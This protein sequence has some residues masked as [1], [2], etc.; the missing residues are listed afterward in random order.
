MNEYSGEIQLPRFVVRYLELKHLGVRWGLV[1]VALGV[2][3]VAFFNSLETNA[4]AIAALLIL[5]VAATG[6]LFGLRWAV[7][8]GIVF[9]FGNMV[10][11]IALGIYDWSDFVRVSIGPGFFALLFIGVLVGGFR[12][13]LGQ[14][15]RQ[16]VAL[17]HERQRLEAEIKERRAIEAELAR[18]NEALVEFAYVVSHDLKAPLRGI[19]KLATWIEEDM[20]DSLS[21]ESQSYFELL[22]SR[23][24][25]MENL[26]TGILTYSRAGQGESQIEDVDVGELLNEIVVTLA[27][28]EGFVVEIGADM[29]VLHTDRIK[30]DQIF[31]NFLSNALKYHDKEEG[32]I[33]V[34]VA[35]TG[36]Y[37]RFGVKDDG[38]GIP[39][40]QQEKVFGIFHVLQSRDT[41]ESTGI[42]L[43]VVKKLVEETGGE[44]G[45]ISEGRGTEF[46]FSWP[47]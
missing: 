24:K 1:G 6:L 19:V 47:K 38:P 41:M 37:Y 45:V 31:S 8:M 34:T 11:W 46:Y 9:N 39:A 14:L 32:V 25:R 5:P 20:G 42:G 36:S 21:D 33:E 4:G 29:P 3:L 22:R 17:E 12:D 40:D 16:S 30:L 43:A 23:I 26:I 44:V 2:Y 7:L 13:L 18:S 27:P 28:R 35:D 15:Q 10:L